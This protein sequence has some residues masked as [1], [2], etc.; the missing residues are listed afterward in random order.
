M[1]ICGFPGGS[2][3]K[4]SACGARDLGGIVGSGRSP[5]RCKRPGWDRGIGKI[6]SAVQETWVGSRGQE[7]PQ[8]EGLASHSGI[9]ALEK[10]PGQGSLADYTVDGVAESRTRLS[11]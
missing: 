11:S 7:D 6:P 3:G 1:L 8:E 2:D 4:E 10:S 5:L 9:L